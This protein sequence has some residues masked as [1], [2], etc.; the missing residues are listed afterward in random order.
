MMQET[1][2]GAWTAQT[3]VPDV[4][5]LPA[6]ATPRIW[7]GT[8]G[9]FVSSGRFAYE[10]IA[11][12]VAVHVVESG[13]GTIC[14]GGVEYC[15]GPGDVF[16]FFP[17]IHYRYWDSM[18]TPWRYT[19]C[20][21]SGPDA[22]Q[23][24]AL[25]GLSPECPHVAGNFAQALDPLF[26]EIAQVLI[27]RKTPVAFAPAAAWRIIDTIERHRQASAPS[28]NIAEIARALLDGHFTSVLSIDELSRQ[29]GVS[30]STLFRKFRDAYGVSPKEYQETARMER[31][32]RLL[33]GSPGSIKQI[34]TACGYEDSHYFSRA[35]RR[36]HGK[37]PGQDR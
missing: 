16:V 30:R 6:G 1:R 23:C 10:Q 33:V 19:W 14:A 26:E 9:R 28:R 7:L 25:A 12:E 4:P 31:A 2:A 36:A 5:D 24:M 20:W 29:L 18:R 34:A 11:N 21:I 15:V 37:S 32:K 13:S 8:M 35:Y 3:Y 27:G 17:G 22:V